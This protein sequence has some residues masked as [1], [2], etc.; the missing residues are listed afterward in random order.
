M[1]TEQTLAHSRD[2][3][4]NRVNEQSSQI[5]EIKAGQAATDAKL[6]ALETA[7]DAGFASLTH[8]L[9]SMRSDNRPN[10]LA[11]FG[12]AVTMLG[13]FGGYSLLLNTPQD[14]RIDQ[15]FEQVSSITGELNDRGQVIGAA[16]KQI[17]WH[18]QWLNFVEQ[19]VD[20]ERAQTADARE[21][22]A[23]LEGTVVT[24]QDQLNAIDNAGSRRWNAKP[25]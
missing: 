6:L 9:R 23:K 19:Q 14:A 5:G 16:L 15:N 7:V 4:W 17:E 11:L 2:D 8:E 13:L 12:I 20:S 1:T 22:I 18:N 24:L 3:I 21:R 25:E 10:T